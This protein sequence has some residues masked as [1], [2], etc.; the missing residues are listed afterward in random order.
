MPV[1]PDNP[2]FEGGLTGWNATGTACAHQPTRGDNVTVKR[3]AALKQH[4]EASV[5]GDYWQ[6]LAVPVG[7]HGQHWIGTAENHPDDKT[8]PGTTAGD[9]ATGTLIS[10]RFRIS[11]NYISFLVGG[12]EDLANLRVELLVD[13]T[14]STQGAISVAGRWYMIAAVATGHGEE[15]LR[16]EVWNVAAAPG[17]MRPDPHPGQFT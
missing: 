3:V 12:N 15:S 13:T 11:N 16:R 7:H 2:D 10:E 17:Q 4:L 1:T 14:P 5:G 8:V 9:E 6:N